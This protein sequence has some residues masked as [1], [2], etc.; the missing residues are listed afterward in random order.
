LP[1]EYGLS[2]PDLT[3]RVNVALLAPPRANPTNRVNA[4]PLTPPR[5]T[6]LGAPMV[7][8]RV[9]LVGATQKDLKN[10]SVQRNF[11]HAHFAHFRMTETLRSGRR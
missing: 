9:G 10:T 1:P 4:A 5:A 6:T 11:T 8:A 7:I 3:N 2:T